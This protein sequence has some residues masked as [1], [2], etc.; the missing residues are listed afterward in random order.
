MSCQDAVVHPDQ[1]CIQQHQAGCL[2]ESKK[3][4]TKL[5]ILIHIERGLHGRYL[6]KIKKKDKKIYPDIK[7]ETLSHSK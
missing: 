6:R 7:E 1:A 2:A 3:L 5:M 4:L